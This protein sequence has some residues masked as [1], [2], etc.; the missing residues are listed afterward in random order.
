MGRG[1]VVQHP[2]ILPHVIKLT[3]VKK[4]RVLY[5]GT[6]GYESEQGYELQ[7][8]NYAKRGCKVD[9]LR[10]TDKADIPSKAELQRRVSQAQLVVVSGGNTLFACRRYRELGLDR[11]LR[12]AMAKGTVMSGGS[13]GAICWFQAGHSDSRDPTSFRRPKKLTKKQ[14]TGWKY[15][16]VSGLG[17]L[18]G[19]CCPHHDQR[20]SNGVLRA[21][22]FN[23]MLKR[24]GSEVGVCIDDQAALIIDGDKFQ[25][26][27][28]DGKSTTTVCKKFL[29]RGRVEAKVFPPSRQHHPLKQLLAKKTNQP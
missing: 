18:P 13:A 24:H 1:R 8:S 11:M 23:G 19:L 9:W 15:I 2:K 3:G 4:P 5:L 26:L 7:A 28:A 14:K 21:E 25:V 16:R 17:F 27:A 29:K 12:E 20:Q 22:D 10:L 6:P